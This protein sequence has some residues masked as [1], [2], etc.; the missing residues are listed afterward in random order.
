MKLEFDLENSTLSEYFNEDT[1]GHITFSDVFKEAVLKEFCIKASYDSDIR[2]FIKSEIKDGLYLKI[3]EYKN[4]AAIKAIVDDVMREELSAQ[5]TGSLIFTDHYVKAVKTAI[6][7]NLG[8][9]KNEIDSYIRR[10]VSAEVEKYIETL[11]AENKLRK[12]LDFQKL[13]ADVIE[14]VEETNDRT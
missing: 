6:E 14:I 13:A 7:K 9:V 5:R 2:G 8:V 3:C 1:E 10:T 4:E 12:Y 11:Y